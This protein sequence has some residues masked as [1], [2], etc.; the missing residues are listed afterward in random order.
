[1]R[2]ARNILFE[3][4]KDTNDLEDLRVNGRGYPQIEVLFQGKHLSPY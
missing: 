3:I 4:R 1:M 2:N